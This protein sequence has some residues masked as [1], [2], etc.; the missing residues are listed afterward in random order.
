MTYGRHALK[1]GP[2]LI[3]WTFISAVYWWDTARVAVRRA[4]YR[5]GAAPC[6]GCRRWQ[7]HKMDCREQ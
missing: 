2:N 7:G 1:R 6:P 3:E 5:T 4:L